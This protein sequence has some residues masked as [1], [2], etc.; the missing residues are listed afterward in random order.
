MSFANGFN[1]QP[2]KIGQIH[3]IIVFFTSKDTI[4]FNQLK[5]RPNSVLISLLTFVQ[6]KLNSQIPNFHELFYNNTMSSFIFLNL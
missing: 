6:N 5:N 3:E 2:T 4:S 1:D